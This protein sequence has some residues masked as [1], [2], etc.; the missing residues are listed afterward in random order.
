MCIRRDIYE[1]EIIAL[2]EELEHLR[3]VGGRIIEERCH[4]YKIENQL[5]KA[6]LE[7]N[8]VKIPDM[9]KSDSEEPLTKSEEQKLQDY[10]NQ[11]MA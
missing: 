8:G 5:L 9:P 4:D 10:K 6:A 11:R 2:N 7:K 1:D 3:R